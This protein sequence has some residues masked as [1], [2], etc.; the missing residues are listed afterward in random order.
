MGALNH[1]DNDMEYVFFGDCCLRAATDCHMVRFRLVKL[2][3]FGKEHTF[4]FWRGAMFVKSPGRTSLAKTEVG[5]CSFLVPRPSFLL[6]WPQHHSWG[7][8]VQMAIVLCP[9]GWQCQTSVLFQHAMVGICWGVLK[10]YLIP[11]PQT[12][13][14]LFL[15]D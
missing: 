3:G 7:G 14:C 5:A 8:Q 15:Q 4:A 10:V 12:C 11:C 2:L 13:N 1:G 6:V 9:S